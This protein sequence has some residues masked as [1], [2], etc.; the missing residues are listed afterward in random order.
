[1]PVEE[2]LRIATQVAAAL[3]AAHEHNVIHRDIKPANLM[4][5]TRGDVKV[6]DFGLAKAVPSSGQPAD[7]TNVLL[8]Q[9]GSI[10]GTVP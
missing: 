8:T 10:V 6:L 1:M 2:G 7:T 5:T 9:P 3:S 4:I